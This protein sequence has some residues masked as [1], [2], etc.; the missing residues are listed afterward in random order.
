MVYGLWWE[1]YAVL[2]GVEIVDDSKYKIGESLREQTQ[3]KVK[4]L[5]SR[6]G[7]R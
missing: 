3:A 2:K 1:D 5:C 7:M 4:D 6:F